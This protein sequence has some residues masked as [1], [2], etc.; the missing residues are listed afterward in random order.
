ME[1]YWLWCWYCWWLWCWWL[2]C[3]L[4]EC[5]NNLGEC[6][7]SRSISRCCGIVLVWK[8][9]C[10]VYLVWVWKMKSV[11]I[12]CSCGFLVFVF[13]YCCRGKLLLFCV[14]YRFVL[15]WMFLFSW[16]WCCVL[17]WYNNWL[18]WL[19]VWMCLFIGLNW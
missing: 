15:I 9:W 16:W 11:C 1:W 10:W 4:G 17:L 5:S 2:L 8:V 3:F 13:F 12:W 7:V 14:M 6:V 19:C 18:F